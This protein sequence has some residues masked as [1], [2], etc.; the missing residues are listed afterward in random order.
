[1]QLSIRSEA[2]T[3][4]VAAL[5][6]FF[7]FM[8][9]PQ[10]V[11]AANRAATNATST[12]NNASTTLSKTGDVI[13]FQ[14]NLDGGVSATNTPVI[15]IRNM[16]TTTMTGTAGAALWLY[17]TT[18][19]S[20]WPEGNATF[21]MAWMGSVGEATT[22]F[23]SL[24]STTI[25]YVRFDKTVPTLSEIT[26]T[27]NNA[28]STLAK[29][30]D[31]I[32]L[33]ATSSEYIGTPTVTLAGQSASV[34]VLTP[35]TAWKATYTVQSG[36][37]NG[38]TAISFAFADGA[39]NSG[40]TVTAVSTGPNVYIDTTGPAIS[41][42]GT[43]P[44]SVAYSSSASYSDAGA[45]AT[46]AHDGSTS[47]SSSGTVNRAVAGSYTITY[48][49]T[50]T[51]GNTSTA[52]RTVTVG[53][54]PGNGQIWTGPASALPGYV[55]PRSQIIH[56]DGRVE[57]L[58]GK[59]DT[60]PMPLAI[61]PISPSTTVAVVYTRQLKSGSAGD[62][63]SALQT[64]LESTGFLIMPK[65]V[66]KGYFGALTR[67]AVMKYQKSVGIESVGIVGPKTR[68]ILNKSIG[69]GL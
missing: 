54:A 63:V 61:A 2:T 28:S 59:G 46:D 67:Q 62:D 5:M 43:N 53:Q 68:A 50:D 18:T 15:S 65:G 1:M 9:M 56:P 37:T 11:F 3:I 27:A 39:G 8:L 25:Q 21:T 41:V 19:T 7:L 42:A 48:T 64:F 13:S 40:T 57:Y 22:T 31:I 49:S 34:T 6:A 23:V 26:I 30:G 45:T 24:A 51:A 14:L 55:A 33:Y 36:N 4:V 16:G 66:A 52:T 29:V 17:S 47:V 58:D 20:G 12:S 44:D 69:T 60:K 32:T 10:S 35:N 38:N